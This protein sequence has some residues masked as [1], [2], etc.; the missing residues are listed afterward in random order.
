MYVC[1]MEGFV[2]HNHLFV[3]ED[4]R[5]SSSIND[6]YIAV[7]HNYIVWVYGELPYCTKSV[8]L[9]EIFF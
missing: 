1:Q 7:N 3:G 8:Q 2:K 4:I 9:L 6:I 5:L